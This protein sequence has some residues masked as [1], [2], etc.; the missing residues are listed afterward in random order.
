MQSQNLLWQH[1]KWGRQS[2][3]N[4]EIKKLNTCIVN[5]N[6]SWLLSKYLT[7]IGCDISSRVLPLIS[8]QAWPDRME[9]DALDEGDHLM[10]KSGLMC[11]NMEIDFVDSSIQDLKSEYDM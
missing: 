9:G 2:A 6:S 5:T 10:K 3:R 1:G 8:S 7:L 4:R 11:C